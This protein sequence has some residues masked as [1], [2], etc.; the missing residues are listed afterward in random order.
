VQERLIFRA[1]A[2]IKEEVERFAPS[3]AD[4]DYPGKLERGAAA[5]AE[6][7]SAAAQ[8]AE[9]GAEAPSATADGEAGAAAA[10]GTD[11]GGDEASTAAA[12]AGAGAGA[13]GGARPGGVHAQQYASLYPPVQ[14]T[15]VCLSKL[16]RSIDARIFSGLAQEA[17]A[18][19]THSIQAA[20]AQIAK[21][22]SPLDAQLFTVRHLLFLREQIAPFDVE[23]SS[24]D[25]DLDFSHM[26]DHMARILSGRSSLFSMS[27]SNAVV[28]MLGTGGPRVLHY[29]VDSKK[30]L[31]KQLKGVCEQVIMALTKVAVE[32]LLGFITKVT[33]VRVAATAHPAAAKPIR[34]QAFASPA[35]LAE[36]VSRV[37]EGMT[38]PLAAAASRMRLYLPNPGTY[39]I[40]FKPVKSNLVEAHTQVASLL[41]AEYPAEEVAGVPLKSGDELAALLDSL[42]SAQAA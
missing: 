26:R 40:L 42:S 6:A 1:Q 19:C 33:A 15:L 16:Y 11:A 7:A 28:R 24:S 23:F 37:N 36:M 41:A 13:A 25:I 30:E 20:S 32:P 35:K 10:S 9:G 3:P 2:F 4:L 18:A 8:Q 38:G 21:R 22:A 27:A 14:S 17:V 29:K 12:A 34:E 39:A 5:E 31:E